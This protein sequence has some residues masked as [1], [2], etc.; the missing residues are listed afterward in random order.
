MGYP[1]RVPE[2]DTEA[3][4]A[5]ERI[6]DICLELENL[7]ADLLDSLETLNYHSA[8]EA[9]RDLN[10]KAIRTAERMRT[11]VLALLKTLQL[12]GYLAPGRSDEVAVGELE[13]MNEL[14]DNVRRVSSESKSYRHFLDSLM[15]LLKLLEKWSGEG[16]RPVPIADET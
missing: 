8:G 12:N 2:R 3:L 9:V 4:N 15:P 5:E 11:Q 6:Q 1:V 14:L 7:S 13:D 16:I 10:A